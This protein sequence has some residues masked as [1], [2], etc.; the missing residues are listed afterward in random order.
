MARE[1]GG[2]QE[3]ESGGKNCVTYSHGEVMGVGGGR[4]ED[5]F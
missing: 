5:F 3:G 2:E 1:G 4:G